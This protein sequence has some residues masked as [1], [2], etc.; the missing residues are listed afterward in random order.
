MRPPPLENAPTTCTGARPTSASPGFQ[1][2][3][4][5]AHWKPEGQRPSAEH[6]IWPLRRFGS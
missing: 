3:R 4:S 6:A 5:G 1:Q 2:R